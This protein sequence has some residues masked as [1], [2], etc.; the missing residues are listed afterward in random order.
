LL[1]VKSFKHFLRRYSE[2][3][4]SVIKI[5]SSIAKVPARR[6]VKFYVTDLGTLPFITKE[7]TKE[8]TA[9]GFSSPKQKLSKNARRALRQLIFQKGK[10]TELILRS[11]IE[12]KALR[13]EI[14]FD[15][16]TLPPCF[17]LLLPD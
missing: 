12:D 8:K 16:L 9:Q 11:L 1:E 6:D 10:E 3:F 13:R 5:I 17:T 7:L 15:P 4:A 2:R 14:F